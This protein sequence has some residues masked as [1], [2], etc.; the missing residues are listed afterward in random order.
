[1]D[2]PRRIEI[3]RRAILERDFKSFA[4]IVELDSDMMH[5]VMMTSKPAL[6]YWLPASMAVMQA[7]REWREVGTS[8]CYTVDAGANVHVLCPEKEADELAMCLAKIPGVKDVLT[9]HVG[10]PARIVEE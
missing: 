7:V 5:A 3:C 9:A 4:S 10:G 6:H 2:T 1:M 8:A